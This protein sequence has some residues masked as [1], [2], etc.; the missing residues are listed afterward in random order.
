MRLYLLI[1]GFVL[2]LTGGCAIAMTMVNIQFVALMW[3]E[4]LGPLA[5]FL[6]KLAMMIGGVILVAVARTDWNRELL[7][8]SAPRAKS[9]PHEK[10][11][12]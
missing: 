8:S 12:A 10:D 11:R 2:F 7:E 4:K 3:L 9:G 1:L 5:S 6:I